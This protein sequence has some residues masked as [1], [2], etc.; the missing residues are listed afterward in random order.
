[1]PGTLLVFNRRNLL[2]LFYRL[3]SGE[4]HAFNIV[5]DNNMTVQVNIFFILSPSYINFFNIIVLCFLSLNAILLI[6][7]LITIE[8]TTF[9]VIT[10]FLTFTFSITRY[11]LCLAYAQR[12]FNLFTSYD[13]N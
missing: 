6:K 7:S 11:P 9:V 5:I 3:Q 12:R 1:M 2:V 8:R 10:Q 4:L 13:L